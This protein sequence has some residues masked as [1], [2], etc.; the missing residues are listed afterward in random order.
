MFLHES[1]MVVAGKARPALGALVDGLLY[2]LWDLGIKV[3]HSVRSIED[4]VRVA[5][6]DMQ[7]KTSLIEARCIAGD[8]ALFERLSRTVMA[9][10]VMGF[11]NDYMQAR[12]EDQATRRAKYGNSACMQ[13]PNLKNGCGGLRDYQN[14]LW[15]SFFKYRTRSLA[16]LQEQEMISASERK[17]L[18]SAYGFLLRVRNGLHYLV[19]RPS[20]VL[21]RSLQPSV[22]L[23]LGYHDRSAGRRVEAFMGDFYNHS[24]NIDFIT[25]T[26]ERRLALIPPPKRLFSLARRF[27]RSKSAAE[28]PVVDGL[29]IVDGRYARLVVHFPGQPAAAD[30]GLPPRA[31]ARVKAPSDHG[32]THSQPTFA[33]QQVFPER[34]A[35]ARNVPGD[36][37]PEGQRRPRAAAMHEV[38]LLGSSCRNSAASPALCSTSST[39]N[40][41]PTN[42]R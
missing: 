22:A 9:K 1:D 42:T 4:C 11:E 28:E 34:R 13:E 25:R 26:V 35:G 10:C 30:A 14:L 38:G 19:N 16:E 7:S 31:T 37:R 8:R 27:F 24:R 41:R 18:D 23:D 32:A 3:G 40:T 5:N 17:Q 20:D 33:G 6:N 29:K 15:M 12:L 36:P 2:T 39:I 21:G